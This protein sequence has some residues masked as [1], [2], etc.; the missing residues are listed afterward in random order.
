MSDYTLLEAALSYGGRV[1][2]VDL[3]PDHQPFIERSAVAA[4]VSGSDVSDQTGAASGGDTLS[5]AHIRPFVEYRAGGSLLKTCK[6]GE[7]KAVGGAPRG[8]IKGFSDDARRRLLYAIGA[9]RRDA[10]LPL[11]ITLTYPNAFPSPA[12]SKRHL[13]MFWQRLNRLVPSHG[14]IWKLE[15]Q[16]RGAPHYHI[17]TWGVDVNSLVYA[18]PGMWSDIASGGDP[19][20]LKWHLGLLG[21]GNVPCV[22]QVRSLRGVWSYASK[23]LGKTFQVAEWSDKWTGRYWGIINRYNIPFGDLVQQEVTEKQV[24]QVQRYQRRFSGIRRSNRSVTIFCDASQWIDK[25]SLNKS[26]CLKVDSSQTVLTKTS[27]VP[28]VSARNECN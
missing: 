18:V 9:V 3:D 6:G 7:T 20:H 23:Y 5:K 28:N 19:L 26:D 17:L 16:E 13:K 2:R 15:P 24:F 21:N 14:S 10:D 4:S 11:F 25:L 12:V 22:Q 8:Q 1:V 27:E